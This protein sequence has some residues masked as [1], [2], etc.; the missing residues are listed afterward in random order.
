M[1][2]Q[3][4]QHKYTYTQ[5]LAVLTWYRIDGV[6]VSV[7]AS[8]AQDRGFETRLVQ[9]KDYKIDICC[10]SSKHAS[11]GRK[12]NDWFG[13]NQDNVSEWGDM[14][15]RGLSFQYASTIKIQLSMLV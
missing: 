5:L 3:Y 14:F 13:R 2:N 8:S 15:I 6:M 12:S 1:S 11:L 4:F 10:I 9:T 7:L